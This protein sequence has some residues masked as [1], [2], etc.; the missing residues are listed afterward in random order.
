MSNND[1]ITEAIEVFRKAGVGKERLIIL[2]CNSE[3]PTY[4]RCAS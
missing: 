2:H 1:E 3:Y 4:A